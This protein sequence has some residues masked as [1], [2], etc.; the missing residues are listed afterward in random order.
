MHTETHIYHHNEQALNGYLAY[1]NTIQKDRPGVLV[2]H[3]WSGCN[4][5]AKKQAERL[6]EMGYVGFAVDMYGDGQIGQTTDEKKAL[7]TPLTENRTYLL[8]R[9]QAAFNALCALPNV[10]TTKTGAIGF[11]FGGLCA[12]DLARSGSAL[13]GLVSFHG[14]LARADTQPITPIQSK[15]LV[16]HGYDDPMVPPEQVQS[17]CDEMTEAHADWQLC[18]YGHTTHAFTNP[19]A[20]DPVL[21]TKY[22][23]LTAHRAFQSMYQFLTDLFSEAA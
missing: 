14:I 19:D 22:N 5:F 1:G 8:E 11:C 21:G 4:E 13:S 18:M 12:L 15:L 20:N 17:F 23:P 16:L 3:D 2:F 6:A 7:M 10:D 9:I